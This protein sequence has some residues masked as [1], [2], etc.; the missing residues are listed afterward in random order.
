M[1][2]YDEGWYIIRTMP[3]M[4]NSAYSFLGRLN[5][6]AFL[7]KYVWIAQWSDRKKKMLTPLFS[8]Y[9]FAKLP[10]AQVHNVYDMP[11]F[12]NFVMTGGWLCNFRFL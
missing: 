3:K 7:P 10:P 11:G 12:I 8:G 4:E 2:N 6:M 1:L 9:I 5:V